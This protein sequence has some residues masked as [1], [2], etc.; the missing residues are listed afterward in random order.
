MENSKLYSK[1]DLEREHALERESVA[2]GV[3][4][5]RDAID[6]REPLSQLKPG[7]ALMDMVIGPMS[8]A[9]R[10]FCVSGKAA[11]P[12]KKTVDFLKEFDNPMK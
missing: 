6:N 12:K 2:I 11:G 3:K 1:E 10:E 8:A 4:K 7:A 9:I 5:Y